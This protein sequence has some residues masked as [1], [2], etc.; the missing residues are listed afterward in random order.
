[1]KVGI[2]TFHHVTNYGALLQAYALWKM[3][4]TQG[5]DVELIDYR[6]HKAV[7]YYSRG[8][9]PISKKLRFNQRAFTKL[10][11]SWKMRK[12]LLSKIGISKK[13]CNSTTC[14]KYF[15]QQY[16][17]VICGSDQIWCLESFR[18]FDSSYF[19]D[20]V[21]N[22]TSRKVSYAASFSDTKTLGSNRESIC[23]LL[24]HFDAISV[25]DSN[26]LQLIGRECGRQ[27]VKVL[28]PTFLVEYSEITSAPKLKEEYLLLYNQSTL[29]SAEENFVKLIAKTKKLIIVSVG[30]YNK[31][32]HKNFI[33]ISPEE[34]IGF[35][36]KA[37]YIVTNTY[38]G[39]IFSI[40]FKKL[41]T[42]F[43]T[44]QKSNKI[45]DLLS[46]LQL[47]NRIFVELINPVSTNEHFLDIDYGSVYEILE[48][49]IL[50]SK[51]YLLK[52]LNGK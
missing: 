40:I 11:Q 9:S 50:N 27:V 15:H 31:V 8:L 1:M 4:K 52:A 26:S 30:N 45:N 35:F 44:E 21:C 12:F 16:D 39:T 17:L 5:Y 29:T 51:T 6:P 48:A 28:D 19:L 22:Q 18:G 33:D 37:S 10:L 34:W 24:S 43:F 7:K 3:I 25:R 32:A 49:E 41:F 20:F 13:K 23:K 2:L 47:K 42:V 38:H 46:N 36:N 14:L